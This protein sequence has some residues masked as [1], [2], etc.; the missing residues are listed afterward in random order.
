VSRANEVF[1]FERRLERELRKLELDPYNGAIL[2]KYYTYCLTED[3]SIARIIKR[4]C[5]LRILSGMLGKQYENATKDDI[6]E[7]VAKIGR[8]KLK[9]NTKRDHKLILRKFYQWLRGCEKK[10]YPPE[11][12]WIEILQGNFE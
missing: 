2:K 7:L 5:H 9:P 4:L 10:Q 11:V 8:A 12:D 1:N 3:I 6:V